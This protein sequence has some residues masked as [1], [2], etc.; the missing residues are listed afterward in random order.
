MYQEDGMN[1]THCL[2]PEDGQIKG[3]KSKSFSESSGLQSPFSTFSIKLFLLH[4]QLL[5]FRLVPASSLPVTTHTRYTT[6]RDCKNR[7]WE[8]PQKQWV[9]HLCLCLVHIKD[10]K[11]TRSQKSMLCRR[12]LVQNICLE[13]SKQQEL[14]SRTWHGSPACTLSHRSSTS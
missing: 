5:F 11:C 12:L 4:P 7:R 13:S 3:N 14:Y 8:V 9:A 10:A 1:H 2:M 6:L